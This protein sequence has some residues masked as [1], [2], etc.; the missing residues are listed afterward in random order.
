MNYYMLFLLMLN[1]LYIDKYRQCSKFEY[2]LSFLYFL[3]RYTEKEISILNT[4]C[5][6]FINRY[7]FH[8]ILIFKVRS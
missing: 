3:K 5:F 4:F 1:Y 6:C 8:L 7:L 2:I